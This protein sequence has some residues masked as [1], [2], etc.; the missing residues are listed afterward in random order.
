MKYALEMMIDYLDVLMS[1]C[2]Y[3]KYEFGFCDG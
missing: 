2:T 1:L 3:E